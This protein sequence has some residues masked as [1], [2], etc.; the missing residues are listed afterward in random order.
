MSCGLCVVRKAGCTGHPGIWSS[1]P[2][3]G[4]PAGDEPIRSSH[5][6]PRSLY[7]WARDDHR[8]SGSPAHPRCCCLALTT[9]GGSPQ[10]GAPSPP[11]REKRRQDSQQQRPS[12]VLPSGSPEAEASDGLAS[13]HRAREQLSLQRP[14]GRTPGHP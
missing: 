1:P 6:P 2:V 8:A 3:S 5:H 10:G 7:F 14:L 12:G 11:V 13:A 4:P 9:R